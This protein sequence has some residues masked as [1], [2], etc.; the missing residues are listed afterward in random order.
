MMSRDRLLRPIA[1]LLTFTL[2]PAGQTG[3]QVYPGALPGYGSAPYGYR[4]NNGLIGP[5]YQAAYRLNPRSYSYGAAPQTVTDY[6][7][8]INAITSI[9]GW[10]GPPAHPYHPV[11][12]QPSVP[13]TELLNDDGTILWPGATPNDATAARA[14][15][16]A[17]EA[18]RGV[19]QESQ[20]YGH[21]STRR[22]ADA[23]NKLTAFARQTLP[24]LKARNAA[25]ADA[26]ERFIVE[27]K[28]TLATLAL[29]Y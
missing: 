6:Q 17:E 29:N 1:A 18:V 23:R 3:A 8:L 22:V 12:P 11:R 20:K 27:L 24:A 19:V 7:S 21:A 25:D 5:G 13:R 16:A 10:Y 4:I 14:R 26:L 2:I 9:P 28:K 15:Q